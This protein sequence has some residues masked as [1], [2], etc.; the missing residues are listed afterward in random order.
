MA[1]PQSPDAQLAKVLS[2][3]MRPRILQVLM[4]L[5]EAS[6]NEMSR[7]LAAPL[8]SVSYHVRIL[9]D[10]GWLELVRTRSRRGAVEHFYRATEPP[11]LDDAR[12]ERLPLTVRRSLARQ[13][14]GQILRAASTAAASGGFDRAGAHVDRLPLSLVDEGWRELSDVLTAALDEAWRVQARSDERTAASPDTRRPSQL[15][16]LHY[17]V[18]DDSER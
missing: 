15:A 1:T 7:E 12:W 2:H 13:T 18:D 16:I 5:G 17:A 9:R 8:G 10:E 4:R 6:P 11:F 3:P 14:V